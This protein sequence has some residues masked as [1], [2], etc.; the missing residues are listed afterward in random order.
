MKIKADA[1]FYFIGKF[2]I[3]GLIIASLYLSGMYRGT[4]Y[5]Y[6]HIVN[7]CKTQK[8]WIDKKTNKIYMC[9]EVVFYNAPQK[10]KSYYNP[11]KEL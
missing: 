2:A 6:D 9:M 10:P 1:I 7:S 11:N 5:Q 8:G 3:Y 4:S